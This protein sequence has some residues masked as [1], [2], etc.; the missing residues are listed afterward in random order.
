MKTV[1]RMVGRKVC[2][3]RGE[4]RERRQK[5]KRT[6]EQ[7]TE[8]QK[9][10][11]TYQ[12][13]LKGPAVDLGDKDLNG[14]AEGDEAA[15]GDDAGEGKGDLQQLVGEAAEGRIDLDGLAGDGVLGL[16]VKEELGPGQLDLGDAADAPLDGEVDLLLLPVLEEDD[17]PEAVDGGV[18]PGELAD[19]QPGAEAEGGG[20]EQEGKVALQEGKVE[21]DALAKLVADGVEVGGVQHVLCAPLLDPG[22]V[23]GVVV[24]REEAGDEAVLVAAAAAAASAGSSSSSRAGGV[25]AG[26]RDAGAALAPGPRQQQVDEAQALGLGDGLVGKVGVEVDVVAALGLA[27]GWSHGADAVQPVLQA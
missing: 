5:N 16:A 6:K 1:K 18:E 20:E 25:T 24:Q 8:E 13:L 15:E 27:A 14:K 3:V 22:A 7:K 4:G 19:Q 12:V 26:R 2:E 10:S 21:G 17:G 23:E 9:N 11:S